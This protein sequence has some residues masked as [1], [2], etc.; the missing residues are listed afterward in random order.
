MNNTFYSEKH[1]H[2]SLEKAAA[3]YLTDLGLKDYF[4]F[5]DEFFE[6]LKKALN[7]EHIEKT[8]SVMTKR[9]NQDES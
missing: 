8:R 1:V 9:M 7:K 2:D 6:E 4:Y 5:K 3:K